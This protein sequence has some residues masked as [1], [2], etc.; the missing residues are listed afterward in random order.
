MKLME[1]NRTNKID[2]A[3]HS[4]EEVPTNDRITINV[5]A[6]IGNSYLKPIAY[7]GNRRKKTQQERLHIQSKLS[8]P[9][10]V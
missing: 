5:T 2:K 7:K 1:E 4:L 8:K 3:D 9:K 10:A 6:T